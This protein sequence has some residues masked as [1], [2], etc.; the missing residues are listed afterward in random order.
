MRFYNV[1]ITRRDHC[2]SGMYPTITNF[3]LNAMPWL[4]F[5][6]FSRLYYQDLWAV[7]QKRVRSGE[8][9]KAGWERVGAQ[10]AISFS[11]TKF[12]RSSLSA[13]FSFIFLVERGEEEREGI[14]DY[15]SKDSRIGGDNCALCTPF[16]ASIC[17]NDKYS[18]MPP[19]I[20]PSITVPLMSG[21]HAL[22]HYYFR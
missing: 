15:T 4:W 5:G 22:R 11:S 17:A 18:K 13:W 7:N 6:P 3:P 2:P 1:G 16:L 10:N 8:R 19:N 12:L 14:I 20:P 9:R 21:L